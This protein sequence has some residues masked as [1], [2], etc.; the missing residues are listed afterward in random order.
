M[1]RETRAMSAVD[2]AW[3]YI[4]G[5]AN[6]A[7]VTGVLLTQEPLDFAHVKE[8]Y[9][10][11]LLRFDRFRQRV[12]ESALPMLTP[13]WEDVPRFNIDHHVCPVKLRR[14]ADKARLMEFLG[15]IVSTPLDRSRPLWQ[16]HVVTNVDGGSALI[17]RFHHCIGDGTAMMALALQLFDTEPDGPSGGP[18]PLPHPKGSM[19]NGLTR[20]ANGA[21]TLPAQLVASTLQSSLDFVLHP[22]LAFE[23][24]GLAMG[25][26]GML[27]AELLRT[28]D[29]QTP[30]KGKFG[31]KKRVA[32]S[33]PVGLADIKTIG[34]L[35]DAKVNDVLVAGMTGAIRQYLRKRGVKVDRIT[36][37]ALVPVDLRPRERALE[38]GNEFGLV[39]LD[40]PIQMGDPLARLRKVKENMDA[41][42]RSPEAIAVYG[43]FNLLGYLPRV[44]EDF[45]VDLFGSRASIVMTNVAGPRQTLYLAGVPIERI[46]FWVPHPGG[47]LGMGV[48]IL[49]Y[50]DSVS[51]AVVADA[52]LVPDPERITEQFRREFA[53]MLALAQPKV[54]KPARRS[55]GRR[56]AASRK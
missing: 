53:E 32:W 42:K 48:S 12:V 44:V 1:A 56:R 28:P 7:Q 51:L 50:R 30:F 37:R 16:V 33:E 8:V 49:S 26:I 4:D 43:L 31:I 22:V 14:P 38:L 13:Y 54:Q 39:L 9:R 17:M 24:A 55:A 46:I 27:V 29:P 45:A 41:L 3:Y 23:R 25:G 52:H 20:S 34:R 47:Q 6:L 11:R 15:E 19:L 10:K 35:C 21:M 18:P 5:P 40:L 2:A 36:Q